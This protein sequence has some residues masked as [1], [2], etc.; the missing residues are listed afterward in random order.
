MKRI[1]ELRLSQRRTGNLYDTLFTR[2]VSVYVTAALLPLGITPNAVSLLN[3]LVGMTAW[4]LIGTATYPLVGVLLIHAYAVLDSV[5]GEL[6]RLTRRYSLQGLFLEDHSAYL[7]INGYWIA[8]GAY[9]SQAFVS[10]WPFLACVGLVAFG[11]QAMPASRRALVKSI[12][13]G[14]PIDGRG[15]KAAG[16]P[17]ELAGLAR[18]VSLDVLHPTNMWVV[19]TTVLAIELLWIGSHISLLAVASG[20]VA[21]SAVK[22]LAIFFRFVTTDSLDLWLSHLYMKAS[23]GPR[24]ETDPFALA[25]DAPRPDYTST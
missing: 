2:R 15:S 18:F 14:R 5:D 7:M 25:G 21:L 12:E 9:L 1:R 20:Y 10:V 19:T 23:E 22:E 3:I 24:G 8:I 4:V 11:R 17:T 13:T 16:D 6:A